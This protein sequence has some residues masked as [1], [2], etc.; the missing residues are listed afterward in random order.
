MGV[1]IETRNL[2]VL[3]ATF[4]PIFFRSIGL[5]MGMLHN[6]DLDFYEWSSRSFC[7]G[8]Y[9]IATDPLIDKELLL[10]SSIFT[11]ATSCSVLSVILEAALQFL[12]TDT[13]SK[14]AKGK[15]FFADK[16]VKTLIWELCHM[17]ERM[18][19]HGPEHRSCGV[20]FFLPIVLKAFPAN[21]SFE[22]S[23]HGQKH[24]FSR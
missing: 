22:V 19:L 1:V 18:L 3:E 2:E 15:G 24:V 4:V 16:F 12:Q 20:G 10:S 21:S 8:S 5:S 14:S 11:L 9:D 6:G 13:I 23:I 17:I 7:Q